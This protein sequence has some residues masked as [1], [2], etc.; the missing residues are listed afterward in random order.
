MIIEKN[1]SMIEP[2][3]E[4]LR[5]LHQTIKKVT[6]DLDTLSFNTAVSQMMIFVNHIFNFRKL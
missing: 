1:W 4:T 2:S 5:L 3:K 6:E